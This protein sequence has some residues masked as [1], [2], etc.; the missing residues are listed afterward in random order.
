MED[1][2]KSEFIFNSDEY[3]NSTHLCKINTY[4]EIDLKWSIPAFVTK[5]FAVIEIKKYAEK[6]LEKMREY[7]G[8]L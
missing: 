1:V 4:S 3:K 7:S 8:V 2:D 5:P 6:S